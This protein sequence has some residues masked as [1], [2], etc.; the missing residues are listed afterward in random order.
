MKKLLNILLIILSFASCKKDTPETVKELTLFYVNDIHGQLD[1]FSKIKQIIDKERAVTNVIVTCAGDVFS[2][3]PITD[4]YTPKGH[5]MIEIMNTIGFDIMTVGNHEFDYGEDIFQERLEQSDFPWLCA[6]VN[7]DNSVISTLPAYK[8]ITV[9][10]I[11]ITFLGLIETNGKPDDIIP[12]THPWKIQNLSFSRPEEIVSQYANLKEQ[13][14]ADLYIALTHLGIFEFYEETADRFDDFKLAKQFPYFDMIIGGHTNYL[15]DTVINGI[16]VLAANKYLN[17]LGRTRLTI[18]NNAIESIQS[19]LIDLNEY[20][21]YDADLKTKIDNYNNS[22]PFLDD[23]IGYSHL[24]HGYATGCFYTDALREYMNV[25]VAIQNTGG[26]RAGLDEG[27]ITK[28]EIYAI[29]PFNNGTVIYSMS[30]AEIK[31]F[32]TGVEF[33]NYFSGIEISQVG[34][35]IEIRDL[36]GNLIPDETIL[37]IGINDYIP[38]VND[39]YF[40]SG[41]LVQNLTAAETLI[42]Y[43]ETINNQVNY[44]VCDCYFKYQP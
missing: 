27:D 28:R 42:A 15:M 7:T 16:P 32:I 11:K 39:T 44:P 38:A 20:T 33:G 36:E 1:N 13:E 18:K 22:M 8:S 24:Y 23:V 12:A 5:P 31:A 4:I 37:T 2:G 40:P 26:V 19:E 17:Y 3:N 35:D 30:V 6:N 25:D 34:A 10:D 14:N 29:A 41:G 43:L 9:N 21:A